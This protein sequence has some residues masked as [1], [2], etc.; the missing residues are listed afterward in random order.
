MDAYYPSDAYNKQLTYIS[1]PPPFKYIELTFTKLAIA[2]S[3]KDV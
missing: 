3:Y 1:L 2:L